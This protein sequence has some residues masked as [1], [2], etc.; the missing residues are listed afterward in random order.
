MKII[1][2]TENDFDE[3]IRLYA[4]ARKLQIDKNAVP[5]PIFTNKLIKTEIAE[6]R[7]FKI[8][9][10]NKIA[11][12]W[13]ITFADP[14]IWEDK[15]ND[16]S[17]YI[18]RITTNPDFKGNNLVSKIV[19]WSFQY[20]KNYNKN[21]IRMDTVGEN[22]GLI[23]HYKKCGFDFIG[24]F[25]LNNTDSLPAHYHNATVSLFQIAI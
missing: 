13:S 14:Q 16:S 19:D 25:K 5:W 18:H 17:I 21:F 11:C 2:C 15:D 20:A 12:L 24:L 23:T 4:L 9:V 10:N 8:V 22:N 6:H 1:N 3:I 7:S